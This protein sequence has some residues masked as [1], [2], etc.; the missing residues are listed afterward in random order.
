MAV[1][2]TVL[3]TK[4]AN[5]KTKLPVNKNVSISFPVAI[6]VSGFLV[7]FPVHTRTQGKTNTIQNVSTGENGFQISFP[8]LKTF[9]LIKVVFISFRVNTH[10]KRCVL[11]RVSIEEAW[12]RHH[13]HII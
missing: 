11:K 13:V 4:I 5:F 10:Q 8:E 3:T 6:T 7:V 12:K 9:L 2:K 1:L